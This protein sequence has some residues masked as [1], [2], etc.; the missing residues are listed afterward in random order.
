MIGYLNMF[1]IHQILDFPN[2]RHS[3]SPGI[4]FIKEIYTLRI[5]FLYFRYGKLQH[6]YHNKLFLTFDLFSY[7]TTLGSIETVDSLFVN[8]LGNGRGIWTI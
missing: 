6:D 2:S 4:N 7:A 3:L 1:Q 8:T 5:P